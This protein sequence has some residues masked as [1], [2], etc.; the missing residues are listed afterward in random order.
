MKKGMRW[1]IG[2]Q[3]GVNGAWLTYSPK[4]KEPSK[5][6]FSLKLG[7]K[8]LL[9]GQTRVQLQGDFRSNDNMFSICMMLSKSL[10]FF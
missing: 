6:V 10:I 1:K 9:E 2:V 7:M 4:V 3:I 5:L 8:Y